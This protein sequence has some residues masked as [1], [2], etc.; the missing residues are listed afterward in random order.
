M[1][2]ARII[3]NAISPICH[4]RL[5]SS[6]FSICVVRD[7]SANFQRPKTFL[8]FDVRQHFADETTSTLLHQQFKIPITFLFIDS[9]K[10][11]NDSSLSFLG[12]RSAAAFKEKSGNKFPRHSDIKT[13]IVRSIS[14][15]L[16]KVDLQ[17]RSASQENLE[18]S[19]E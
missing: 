7:N 8:G 15:F 4:T 6:S 10:R 5:T 13:I 12:Q 18:R 14:T 2:I 1:K 9:S 16:A 19:F 11:R 3:Q 17:F